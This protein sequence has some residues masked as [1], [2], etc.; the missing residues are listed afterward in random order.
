M[1]RRGTL[2][3]ARETPPDDFLAWFRAY[4]SSRSPDL[5]EKLTTHFMPLVHQVA[6]RYA[7]SGIPLDDL[8]Q[9]GYIGLMNAV[10]NFDPDRRVKFETYAR[11]LIAGEIRHYL[12]DQG[13]TVRRPRW[14]YEM[15]HRVNRA[16]TS[17]TQRIGRPPTPAEIAREI[18]SSE[19]EVVEVL[20]ARESLRLVSLDEEREGDDG[21]PIAQRDRITTKHVAGSMPVEE[22]V[23]VHDAV[24]RL[25]DLQ[26]KVI[27]YLFFMD[28]T[29]TEAARRLGIS[30]KHVSRV[31]H[32]ALRRLR[33]SLRPEA[34]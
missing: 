31:M 7:R 5:H 1:G 23:L 18:Q 29:Q 3:A 32:A 30:Q 21:A 20:Q 27:Y 33:E 8:H 19:D 6:R 34:V 15:D 25:S 10:T 2:H 4:R 22:R 28:L 24:E 16:V 26:R 17:L 12:R 13:T 11:H 9:I 14:L